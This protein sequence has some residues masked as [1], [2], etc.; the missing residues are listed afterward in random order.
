MAPRWFA[1]L[2]LLGCVTPSS[3]VPS[4]FLSNRPAEEARA[5]VQGRLQAE[6]FEL[7]QTSDTVPAVAL[8]QS[9]P[10]PEVRDRWWRIELSVAQDQ[11]GRTIVETTAGVA[12]REQGPYTAATASLMGVI[13]KLAASCTW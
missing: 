6:G 13:G 3:P 1:P 10:G 12:S 8:L 5:C 7:T 4:R 9:E 11:G 2:L